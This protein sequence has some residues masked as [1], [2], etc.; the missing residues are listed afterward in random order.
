METSILYVTKPSDAEFLSGV[1][2]SR[3]PIWSERIPSLAQN[4]MWRNNGNGTFT[5]V[6]TA[7]GLGG[8]TSEIAS[9]GTDYNNDRA[10]DLVVTS[11]QKPPI[12]FENPREG[13]FENHQFW[14]ESMAS[15]AVG[16]AALDFDHDG[17]M[18]L[19]FTHWGA[20]C[21]KS[22]A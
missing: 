11:R 9:L 17:W 19:A 2:I 12:I 15:P 13:V 10:V 4:T 5:D 21:N 18:D 14:S 7:I 16:V 8:S 22:L 1:P 20:P 6:S 3:P